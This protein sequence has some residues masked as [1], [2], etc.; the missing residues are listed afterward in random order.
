MG[1]GSPWSRRRLR[2]EGDFAAKAFQLVDQQTSVVFDVLGVAAVEELPRRR[3]VLERD[4][5]EPQI[6]A[7]ERLPI[8]YEPSLPA[9][10]GQ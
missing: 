6:P 1:L 3:R 5:G 8:S 7:C 2:F 9:E 10:R 4:E